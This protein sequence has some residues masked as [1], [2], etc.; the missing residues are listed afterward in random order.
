MNL[1]ALVALSG[2]DVL[3]IDTDRQGSA[4]FWVSIRDESEARCPDSLCQKFGKS[5]AK[6]VID[7]AGR[8][9][10]IVIDAGGRDSMELRYSLG[11]AD[12]VY[13][14]IQP[15]QF[16]LVTL[17]QM[18]RLVEQAQALNPSLESFVVINRAS[19]NPSVTDTTS[20]GVGV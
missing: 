5:L 6:D 17:D 15:S 3:L 18:D 14:P 7:L 12:R 1:A 9:E 2:K 19:T 16:D 13:I 11:V 8:Y 4:N 10:E 20:R